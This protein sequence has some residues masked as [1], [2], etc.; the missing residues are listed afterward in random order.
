MTEVDMD[1]V[2]LELAEGNANEAK[3][4]IYHTKRAIRDGHFPIVIDNIGDLRAYIKESYAQCNL[5][6]E[7]ILRVQCKKDTVWSTE[8]KAKKELSE[9]LKRHWKQA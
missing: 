3:N 6:K 2:H 1:Q 5:I 8:E 9:V 7:D 4:L